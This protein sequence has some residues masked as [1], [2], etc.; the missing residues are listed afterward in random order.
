MLLF[1]AQAAGAEHHGGE[2]NL[3]VPDLSRVTFLNGISGPTL[4]MGGLLDGEAP[5]N[6][7]VSPKANSPISAALGAPTPVNHQLG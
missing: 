5:M 7:G 1:L 4:L 6:A 3:V 2:V